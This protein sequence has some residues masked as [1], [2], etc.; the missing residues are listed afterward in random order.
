MGNSID[1]DDYFELMIRNAWH[2]SG[3]EELVRQLVLPGGCSSHADGTQTVEEV[4]NDIGM[5]ADDKAAMKANI[6]AQGI[7]VSNIETAGSVDHDQAPE[8]AEERAR[9]LAAPEK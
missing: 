7:S 2:I 1:D 6:E 9:E 4:M 5:K 8:G 3:G